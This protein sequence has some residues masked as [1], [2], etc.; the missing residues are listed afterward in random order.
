MRVEQVLSDHRA[1][2][3]GFTMMRGNNSLRDKRWGIEETALSRSP[4]E[5]GRT[6]FSHG[7]QTSGHS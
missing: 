5:G 1:N 2:M 3:T 6:W 7:S 4:T